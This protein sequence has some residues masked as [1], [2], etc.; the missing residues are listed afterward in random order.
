MCFSVPCLIVWNYFLWPGAKKKKKKPAS[1]CSAHLEKIFHTILCTKRNTKTS[2]DL[3]NYFNGARR[4]DTLVRINPVRLLVLNDVPCAGHLGTNCGWHLVA[5][6]VS[7]RATGLA[8]VSGNSRSICGVP[9]VREGKAACIQAQNKL[10]WL[11]TKQCH[12]ERRKWA[13]GAT[14]P[15]ELKSLQQFASAMWALALTTYR[16]FWVQARQLSELAVNF[17]QYNG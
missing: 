2:L 10:L 15:A 1:F 3:Q 11:K 9:G 12:F 5:L 17:P 13:A 16:R 4:R 8:L 6:P 7:A 14:S